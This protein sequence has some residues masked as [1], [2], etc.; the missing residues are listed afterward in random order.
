MVPEQENNIF[1]FTYYTVLINLLSTLNCM[2]KQLKKLQE[3]QQTQAIVTE[4]RDVF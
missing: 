3:L 2:E 1:G 4:R